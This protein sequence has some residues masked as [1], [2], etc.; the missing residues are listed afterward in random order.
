MVEAIA[1]LRRHETLITADAGDYREAN[2]KALASAA[3]PALIADT[4]MRGNDER[5]QDQGRHQAKPDLLDDKGKPPKE[6]RRFRP[7][8]FDDD[9]EAGTCIGPAGKALYQKGSNGLHNG[10]LA[11]RFTGSQRDGVPCGL[12]ARCLRTPERTRVRQVYF[13]GKYPAAEE[14]HTD[15]RK[16]AI[17]REEGRRCDDRRFAR[18]K[19]VFGNLWAN[20]GWTASPCGGRKKVDGHWKLYCRTHNLEK[21]AH[22]EY[23]G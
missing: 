6:A 20:S 19:P 3:I 16:R 8:D 18:V 13:R 22:H 14:S 11:T 5:F 17:D 2:L 21:L 9:R 23:A 12:R 4:A 1:L 10:H 7:A 15:R